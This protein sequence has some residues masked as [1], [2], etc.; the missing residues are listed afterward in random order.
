MKISKFEI[1]VLINIILLGIIIVLSNIVKETKYDYEAIVYKKDYLSEEVKERVEEIKEEKRL[2]EIREEAERKRIV[3]DNLT[4][5]EL[6]AKINRSLNSTLTNKGY[7]FVDYSLQFGVDPYL[8][9]AIAL[10][11]TGCKWNCSYLTNVCNNV[12]GQKGVGCGDYASFSSLEEG[13]YAFVSNIYYNYYLFGLNTPDLM[14]SKYAESTTWAYNV[15][16]YINEI[17]NS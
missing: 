6:V 10:H 9:T 11:E 2:E 5:D 17:K 7:L 4:Y 14:N 1:L 12:G 8:T 3:F 16:R 13:I 15:N